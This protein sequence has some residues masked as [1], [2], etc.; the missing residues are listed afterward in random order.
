MLLMTCVVMM[1]MVLVE[2]LWEENVINWQHFVNEAAF[3]I[4]CLSL[5]LFSGVLTETVQV[6]PL[7]L[8]LIGGISL[9]II[10]NVI[11]ILYDSAQFVRL[12]CRRYKKDLLSLKTLLKS[13][14]K[15]K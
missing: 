15:D 12:L 6:Q 5:M 1:A 10:Y 7:S 9:L 4:L 2:S 11:V 8:L 14:K 13:P 3:Y